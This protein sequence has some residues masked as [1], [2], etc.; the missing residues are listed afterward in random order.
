M[1]HLNN[2]L[3]HFILYL[4]IFSLLCP[5]HKHHLIHSLST[6]NQYQRIYMTIYLRNIHK[7]KLNLYSFS[8]TKLSLIWGKKF[9]EHSKIKT[10]NLLFCSD[11][12]LSLFLSIVFPTKLPSR[13][14]NHHSLLFSVQ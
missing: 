9:T 12:Y 2:F 3:V 8:K 13:N 4:F 6:S 10:K 11:K 14:E 1:T 5:E 7:M